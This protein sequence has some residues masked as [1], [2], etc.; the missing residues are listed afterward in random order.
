MNLKKSPF[1][2]AEISANHCG[3]IKKAMKLIKKLLTFGVELYKVDITPYSDVG[4]M[5][6]E[7][8][9]ERKSAAILMD[10]SSYLSEAIAAIWL[11]G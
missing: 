11:G 3:S 2:I 1:F 6:K 7:E 5:S 9:A 10:S 8:Y 4:E